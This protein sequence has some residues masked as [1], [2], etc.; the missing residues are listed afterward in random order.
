[1]KKIFILLPLTFFLNGCGAY[2]QGMAGYSLFRNY[3]S[4]EVTLFDILFAFLVMVIVFVFLAFILSLLPK[5]LFEQKSQE[6]RIGFKFGLWLA[7]NL[8]SSE[9]SNNVIKKS[10]DEKINNDIA[11]RLKKLEI[12]LEDNTITEDEYKEQRKKIIKD[13]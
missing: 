12:L 3:I 5:H 4:G 8:K 10:S 9:K 7:K 11:Q 2:F 13:V 6:N 1:M